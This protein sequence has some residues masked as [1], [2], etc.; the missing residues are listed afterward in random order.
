MRP[1]RH[2]PLRKIAEDQLARHLGD[3]EG[4]VRDELATSLVRQ[5]IANE[6]HAGIVTPTHQFWFRAVAKSDG[7]Q[8]GCS[9]EEGN[10]GLVLSRD[11]KVDEGDVPGLLH[12][13]NLCQVAECVTVAG[14]TL[15]LR[16]EPKGR[17]VRCEDRPGGDE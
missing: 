2:S 11:W 3:I 10:W 9:K 12:R 13:L 1:T 6:G 7:F 14:G 8:V 17:T 15:R 5:W 16:V 4:A